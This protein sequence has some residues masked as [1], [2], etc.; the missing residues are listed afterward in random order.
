SETSTSDIADVKDG[1]LYKDFKACFKSHEKN[2]YQKIYSFIL[3]TDVISAS[4][5][6]SNRTS[7][8][9]LCKL[10]ARDFK[11]PLTSTKVS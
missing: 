6:D 7:F 5:L 11:A 2:D 9:I 8:A 10:T 3:N 4:P 1:S